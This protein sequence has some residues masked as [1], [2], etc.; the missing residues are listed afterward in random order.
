MEN[1]PIRPSGLDNY[2]YMCIIATGQS[3]HAWGQSSN[4]LRKGMLVPSIVMQGGERNKICSVELEDGTM[5]TDPGI[6]RFEFCSHFKKILQT[7]VPVRPIDTTVMQDGPFIEEHNALPFGLNFAY[8]T[9][10]PK[11]NLAESPADYRPISCCNVI[12][13]VASI[14][15]S[16]LKDVLPHVIDSAQGAFV[17]GLSIVSNICLA[18]QILNGYGRSHLSERLAWKIDLRKVLLN[19]V[20]KD[21]FEGLRGLRQGDPLSPFLFTIVMEYLSRI[22]QGINEPKRRYV[23]PILGTISPL[24]VKYLYISLNSKSLRPHDCSELID[25]MVKRINSWSNM[26]LSR[27][28][29]VVL[30]KSVLHSLIY[31]CT[32]IFTIPKKVL[33]TIN[34]LCAKFLWNGHRQGRGMYLVSWKDVW[35]AKVEGGLG[36]KCLETMNAAI[37]LTHLW[38]INQDK[39]NKWVQWTKAYWSKDKNWRE[40]EGKSSNSWVLKRLLKCQNLTSKCTTFNNGLQWT[41]KG[42]G[43]TV[44]D[45]YDTLID[46]G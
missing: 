24:P 13:T 18:H 27:A 45:T 12:K 41:D 9:L 5:S 10:I 6:I 44:K 11:S 31:Y 25:R 3:K 39:N 22:L 26:L 40:K 15:A 2:T 43:F 20:L 46:P 17:K 23:T 30:I 8:I 35:K 14:L 21:Y 36:I 4:G 7:V 16:R 29:R 1:L 28:G 38:D 34:S 37:F 33:T 42:Q 19:G 32:R